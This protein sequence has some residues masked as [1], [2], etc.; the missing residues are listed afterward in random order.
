MLV[1]N[2]RNKKVLVTGH[3]GFKGSWISLWLSELGADVSGFSL[4]LPS[5]PNLF[6]AAGVEKKVRH[7]TGDIRDAEA[8]EKIFGQT[9]P[10]IVFHLAAQPLVRS[11]HE[12]PKETF[13]VNVGGTVNLLECVRKSR[14][15][16]AVVNITT[17]K[18]YENREDGKSFVEGDP[19]GGDDPYS[20]SKAASELVTKAYAKSFFEEGAGISPRRAVGVAT[21]RS[22]NVIGGG[23]WG[24]DRLIPDLVTALV[25][26]RT[27][28]LRYPTATRPWQHVLDATHGYLLLAAALLS[29]PQKF[30]G[31]W[32]FGPEEKHA[33]TVEE[34]VNFFSKCW[35]KRPP[36]QKERPSLPEARYLELNSGKARKNLGWR[37][38]WGRERA[39]RETVKWYQRFYKN[40]RTA[41]DDCL[42]QI[43]GFMKEFYG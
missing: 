21:A 8:L 32:N 41:M 33:A 18:C 35:G 37:S 1:E 22:G 43:G 27:L 16:Q 13:D 39:I 25:N 10:E 2:F 20:A 23:D 24:R 36:V 26:N 4:Y 5:Q 11:S 7:F 34:M 38:L 31:A 29:D 19:L 40:P 6:E 30:G 17:D 28:L 3:T 12:N 14:L 15:V 42:S 9:E